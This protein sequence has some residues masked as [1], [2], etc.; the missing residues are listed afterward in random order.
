MLVGMQVCKHRLTYRVFGGSFELLIGGLI[1]EEKAFWLPALR[2]FNE[3]AP[4]TAI[5]R[6]RGSLHSENS[7]NRLP[8]LR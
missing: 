7:T 4:R 1:L 3:E 6:R 8:A 5:I 2:E